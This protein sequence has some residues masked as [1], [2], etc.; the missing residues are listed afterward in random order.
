MNTLDE[1][2]HQP[3]RLKVMS[4]L[5]ALPRRELLE[6]MRLKRITGATDGNLGSHLATLE[7]AGYV[8]L[9]K[10]FTGKKPRTRVGLT[11]AGQRAF[12]NH[13]TSLREIL[14]NGIDQLENSS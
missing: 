10:D 13:V 2:I 12:Q 6:F 5:N 7:K 9:V 1:I 3:V 4:A 8:Q 11:L 14:E